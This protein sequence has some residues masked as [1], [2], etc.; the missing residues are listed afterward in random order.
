[1]IGR[2][3]YRPTH[4][5]RLAAIQL[6]EAAKG[7]ADLVTQGRQ[8]LRDIA[9]LSHI[10]AADLTLVRRADVVLAWV[11]TMSDPYA[12]PRDQQA[13]TAGLE[14]LDEELRAEEPDP[15]PDEAEDGD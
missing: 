7:R 14:R 5:L 12:T 2:E 9:D 4:P 15:E 11:R 13:A 1:M 3:K 8:M 10:A 6:S